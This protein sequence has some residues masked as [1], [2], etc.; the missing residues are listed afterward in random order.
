MPAVGY[1]G[2]SGVPENAMD[3][4]VLPCLPFPG[5]HSDPEPFGP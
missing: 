2:L 4:L 3:P 1:F 5:S